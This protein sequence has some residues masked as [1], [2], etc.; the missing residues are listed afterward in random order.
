M[1]KIGM[2]MN[3]MMGVTLSFCLSLVGNLTSGHFTVLGFL[4]SFAASTIVS[5]IIGFFVPLK[6]LTDDFTRKHNLEQGKLKTRCVE[7]LISDLI[8]T[9]VITLLMVTMAYFMA[10][11][12]APAGAVHFLPMFLPSLVISLI[13]AYII[14]FI[15][16]PV[17]IGFLMKKNGVGRPE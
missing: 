3:I 2:Q 8:Y 14:I 1:K 5:L 10:S 7:S 13:V 4:I 11:K 16:T 12:N 15:I 9:P 17:Y 6:K